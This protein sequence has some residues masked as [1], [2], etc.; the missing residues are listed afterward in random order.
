[1]SID[2]ILRYP[3]YD[4]HSRHHVGEKDLV[5]ARKW[6]AGD[7]PRFE[8]LFELRRLRITR[9]KELYETLWTLDRLAPELRRA[10]TVV[11]L[12]AG[13]GLFGLIAVLLHPQLRSVLAIDKRQPLCYERAR[14]LLAAV[15]PHVKCRTRYARGLLPSMTGLP[16]ADFVVGV[17]CCGA[18]TDHLAR[19][20][21][22]ARRPFAV[23]PCCEGRKLLPAP[24][25]GTA[26][27]GD[28]IPD[29]VNAERLARWRSWGYEVEER[30]LPTAVTDRPRLLVASF[31][32]GRI[33]VD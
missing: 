28:D 18:L 21:H 22:E 33:A 15:H 29:I 5:Y 2:D 32:P 14:E 13:H 24:L 16:R 20:A 12:G 31:G 7:D 23:V 27:P 3:E 19:L 10:R 4:L 30:R 26:V 1:M 6:L 25:R 17:H 9:R 8:A 11:E